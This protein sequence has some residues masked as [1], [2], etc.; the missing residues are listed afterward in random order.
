[1]NFFVLNLLAFFVHQ[2]LDLC[3]RHYQRCRSRFSF[4]KEFWNVLKY[5]IRLILFRDFYHLLD[6]NYQP[7]QIRAP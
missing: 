6:H 2:I 7:V 4:R 1:M 3:D 5:S